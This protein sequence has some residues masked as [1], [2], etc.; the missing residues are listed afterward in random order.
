LYKSN[1]KFD[2]D[3]NISDSGGNIIGVGISGSGN[4]IGKNVVIGTGTIN[5]DEAK[6]QKVPSEYKKAL[7]DFSKV[8]N[9]QLK[10]HQI[11]EE[12]V[13]SINH[14][15]TELGKELENI[16]PGKENKV[17]YVKK[18]NLEGKTALLVQNIL[19]VLPE[20]AETAT[21]FT[22]L[23]PLSKIIGKT[24]SSIIDAVLEK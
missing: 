18:A 1:T 6:I 24:I 14:D 23:A 15:L 7:E 13:K 9:E 12:K 22:P 4:V 19:N 16:K 5:I 21:I 10:G 17:D 2:S 8:I 11:T 3:S 20:A